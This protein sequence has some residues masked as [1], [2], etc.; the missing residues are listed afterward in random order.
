MGLAPLLEQRAVRSTAGTE[1]SSSFSGRA[2]GSPLRLT[3][4]DT[5]RPTSEAA[6]A[7]VL[8]E[9]AAVDAA[10]SNY[11]ED[12]SLTALNR[13]VDDG[14][15]HRVDGRLYAALALADRARRVTGGR[16]DPRVAVALQDLGRLG[17][18]PVTAN[19]GPRS[20]TDRW[21][22]RDPRSRVAA[23][24]EPVDLGGVGKGLALRWAWTRLTRILPDREVGA[25]L[26]CG[27][28]LIGRGPGSDGGDWLIAIEDPLSGRSGDPADRAAAAAAGGPWPLAVVA[29]RGGA[30]CTSSTRIARWNDP[31]G[32]PVHHLIDPRTGRP[33]GDGLLAVTVACPDPAWAEIRTKELFLAGSQE[34]AGIARRRDLA[35][36]WVTADG[37]LEMTPRARQATRWP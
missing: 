28:D 5:D 13:R 22:S 2:L 32:R 30:I 12:S 9:F 15:L 37:T 18:V 14:A 36:W 35:A 33:G 24:S 23:A 3:L 20:A 16:F 19:A 34:I 11:R 6:W 17:P 25:L 21:L 26:D 8:D 1:R 31:T 4:T 10:L 7:V 27:G 29:L